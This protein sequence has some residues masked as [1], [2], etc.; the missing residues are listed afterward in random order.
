MIYFIKL[1]KN[2][3]KYRVFCNKTCLKN[4]ISKVICMFDQK[5]RNTIALL[6]SSHISLPFIYFNAANILICLCYNILEINDINLY[7]K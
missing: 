4:D 2:P 7:E 5:A 1:I 3:R 6:F